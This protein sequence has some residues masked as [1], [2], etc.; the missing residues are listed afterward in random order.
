MFVLSSDYVLSGDETPWP[1]G[2][3]DCSQTLCDTPDVTQEEVGAPCLQPGGSARRDGAEPAEGKR[4]LTGMRGEG[5][6]GCCGCKETP[7]CLSSGGVNARFLGDLEKDQ[8][9]LV[10]STFH[11]GTYSWAGKEPEN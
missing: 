3:P 10:S 9:P 5:A 8:E 6:V 2:E 7:Q 1:R 11:T 4:I